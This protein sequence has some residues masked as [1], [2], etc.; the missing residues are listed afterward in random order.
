[1]KKSREEV[2]AYIQGIES[3][4]DLI[5]NTKYINKR[6]ILDFISNEK[7]RVLMENFGPERK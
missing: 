6:E 1:M 2:W 7:T 4:K 3:V 5:F